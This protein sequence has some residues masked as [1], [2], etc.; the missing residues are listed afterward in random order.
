MTARIQLRL[1]GGQH[2][3]LHRH[4]FPGDGDEHGA[5]ILA[6][7]TTVGDDLTL[8][9][10]DIVLARDGLDYVAG[11]RGYR[12][13]TAGFVTAQSDRAAREVVA[14]VDRFAEHRGRGELAADGVEATLAALR[15]GAVEVLLVSED[16]DAEA[17]VAVD[18]PRQV[19]TDPQLL[20]DSG[21][22]D[23]VPARL[24]DAAILAALHGGA[25]V[26][27]VP[28]HGPNAPDGAL[29]AITRF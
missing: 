3:L 22:A 29:G 7:V 1:T 25:D 11:E 10:R 15:T 23:V 14:A 17:H 5:V 12:M 24:V 6:G 9:A 13:L 27:V 28:A 20:A 8:V 26:L 19:A 21:F 18:D 4:L 2:E 16:V